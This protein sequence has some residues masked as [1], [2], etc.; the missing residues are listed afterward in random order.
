MRSRGVLLG[1]GVAI[2]S[3]A[4]AAPARANISPA[5]CQDNKA[6]PGIG[7]D[8]SLARPGDIVNFN[9]AL[10]NTG[11]P[12]DK[13][14]DITTTTPLVFTLPDHTG[15]AAGT[16]TTL[17]PANSLI[18]AGSVFPIQTFPWTVAVDPGVQTATAHIHADAL[19]HSLQNGFDTA[20]IDRTISIQI[21]HPSMVL[22]KVAN[23]TS[24][25]APLTVTYTYKLTNTGDA[26]IGNVNVSDAGAGACSPLVYSSGDTNADSILQAQVKNAAGNITTAA[27]TWTYTCQRVFPAAGVFPNVATATGTSTVDNKPVPP[28][29]ANASVSVTVPAVVPAQPPPAVVAAPVAPVKSNAA[30]CVET[31]KSLSLRAKE[32]TTVRITVNNG[33]AGAK[34]TIKGPGIN[35]TA[36][37]NSKGVAT[38]RVRATKAGTLTITAPDNCLRASKVAVKGARRTHS[39]QVPK[40][41]G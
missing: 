22:T 13:P 27:E 11:Q 14:C 1:I 19:L 30:T 37:T 8:V 32:L 2:A 10:R 35:K 31:P 4:W 41:T 21:T 7:R 16:A 26:D 40:V 36:K 3:L 23:P 17:L 24:G 28:V 33:A 6:D 39:R 25:L 15:A 18:P 20:I 38:F 34:V 9:V 12:G 29:Q 5:G